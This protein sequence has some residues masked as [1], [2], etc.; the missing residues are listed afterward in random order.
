MGVPLGGNPGVRGGVGT[1]K[2]GTGGVDIVGRGGNNDGRTGADGV[3]RDVPGASDAGPELTAGADAI[4]VGCDARGGG[5]EEAG[6][7]GIVDRGASA[8]EAACGIEGA[9]GAAGGIA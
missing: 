4:G 3:G 7:N 6:A 5:D 9:V 1:A 8:G 2:P